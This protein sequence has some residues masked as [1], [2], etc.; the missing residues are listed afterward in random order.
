MVL[1]LFESI[2]Y[3]FQNHFHVKTGCLCFFLRILLICQ[4]FL[5]TYFYARMTPSWR[6]VICV[7]TLH[8]WF[9]QGRRLLLDICIRMTLQI[10]KLM[11]NAFKAF[12][13]FIQEFYECCSQGVQFA[14][15]AYAFERKA[16]TH[17]AFGLRYACIAAVRISQDGKAW[18]GGGDYGW[19]RHAVAVRVD[20][21]IDVEV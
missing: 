4:S 17:V 21:A 13:L 2:K 16:E 8:F 14:C 15:L 9:K 6:C 19:R 10:V 7:K 11:M 18:W 1:F 5:I 20:G 12:W 3:C